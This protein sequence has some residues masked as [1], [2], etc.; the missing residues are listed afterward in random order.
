LAGLRSGAGPPILAADQPNGG[1][2]EASIVIRV[3]T[4]VLLLPLI[5]S[6]KAAGQDPGALPDYVPLLPGVAAREPAVDPQKGYRVQELKPAVYLITEGA[7]EAMF[8][9]TGKGVVLFDAPPSFAKHI[10]Q[11]VAET[12]REPIVALVYSHQHVDHIGGAGLILE[13]HPGIEIVAEKGTT[14]FLREMNDPHRPIPTRTFTDHE[15]LKVGSLRADMTLGHWHCPEGDLLISIP[16]KK[17]LMAVD[18]FSAGATPFMDL[19]L[20]MNMH[21]YLKLFDRLA[22]MDFDVIVPGH[23]DA[24]A[25]RA[26]LETAKSYVHDVLETISRILGEDHQALKTRAVQQYGHNGWAV[27][28]VLIQDEV[29]QCARDIKNRWITKLDGVDIWAASHCRT[30]LIYA[31][32]DVGPR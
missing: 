12:T 25:T 26:D 13:Q 3:L 32:W 6:A 7:Y 16:D 30:A 28:S 23:H 1:R 22:A 2:V 20:T 9:T 31:Q 4:A 18:G 11:A 14:E 10:S 29:D 27:A 21:E 8:V 15:T 19:D 24:P 5:M 17:V